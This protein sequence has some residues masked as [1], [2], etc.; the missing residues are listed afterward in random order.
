[1]AIYPASPGGREFGGGEETLHRDAVVQVGHGRR[2]IPESAQE[3]ILAFGVRADEPHRLGPIRRDG[4]FE[5]LHR[6]DAREAARAAQR[7]IRDAGVVDFKPVGVFQRQLDRPL[8][9]VDFQ[10]QI[11]DG[12]RAHARELRQ[13]SAPSRTSRSWSN[14]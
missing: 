2:V 4:P 3:A 8:L 7:P 9:A 14:A 13:P 11:V 1:M 12:A 10:P 5:A 6:L